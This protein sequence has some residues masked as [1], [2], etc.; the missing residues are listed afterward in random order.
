MFKKSICHHTR[1]GVVRVTAWLFH[2]ARNM[3]ATRLKRR[4][5]QGA[6]YKGMRAIASLGAVTIASGCPTSRSTKRLA[7]GMGSRRKST[8]NARGKSPGN[9]ISVKRK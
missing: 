1:G 4:P 3:N 8:A 6:S 2:I 5:P 9:G 7:E